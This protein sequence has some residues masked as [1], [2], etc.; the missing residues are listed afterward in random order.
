MIE[1]FGFKLGRNWGLIFC[2]QQ[3]ERLGMNWVWKDTY[4]P[5]TCATLEDK[6]GIG[7][8]KGSSMNSASCCLVRVWKWQKKLGT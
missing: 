6:E 1:R 5:C 8:K 7:T 2:L 3:I 4:Y